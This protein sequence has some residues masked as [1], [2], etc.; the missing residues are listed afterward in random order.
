MPGT[1]PRLA[2]VA[3]LSLVPAVV[4]AGEGTAG[5]LARNALAAC[6][7]GRHATDRDARRAAFERGQALAERAVAANDD[8]ANAHFSLFC[9][10]GELMRLDG[11]SIGSVLALRRLMGELDRTLAL[12]PR[13]ADALAAKG[14]LL[15][16]LPRLFGGDAT[17]GEEMLRQVIQLDPN[18]VS[19]RLTL[20]QTCEAKGNRAEAIDFAARALQIARTQGRADKVAEAQAILAELSSR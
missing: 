6:E 14:T 16:R 5:E 20:A 7:E 13:H 2:L 18:A 19:S 8:D 9:N 3:L 12:D 11:E 4:H 15:V 17:K 1:A 10:M